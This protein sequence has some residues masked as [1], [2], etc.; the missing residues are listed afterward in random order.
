MF[1]LNLPALPTLS[2]LILTIIGL[3]STSCNNST[4]VLTKVVQGDEIKYEFFYDKKGELS[5]VNFRNENIRDSF[6]EGN[7]IF[8]NH[9]RLTYYR[10]ISGDLYEKEFK[11]NNDGP[12]SEVTNKRYVGRTADKLFSTENQQ[13]IYEEGLL[14]SLESTTEVNVSY[15]S[16]HQETYEVFYT[17]EIFKNLYFRN[18]M[19]SS[20]L[21]I[22]LPVDQ[23]NG[24]CES[25]KLIKSILHTTSDLSDPSSSITTLYSF[26]YK[27]DDA[28]NITEISVKSDAKLMNYLGE[29][30]GPWA[31][32]YKLVY[33]NQN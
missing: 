18:I 19:Y 10:D 27:F 26:N 17:D 1:K 29:D 13:Y 11:Y 25:N 8:D 33:S 3:F 7:H 22:S 24:Y 9:N 28:R 20:I 16:G 32:N 21:P 4:P 12:L 31:L 15:Q 14:V 23:I 5:S 2:F 30:L 6:R